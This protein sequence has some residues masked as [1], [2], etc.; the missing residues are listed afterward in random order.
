MAEAA[1][2]STLRSRPRRTAA[3]LRWD[4]EADVVVLGFGGAGACAAIEAKG[5]GA[6]VL[7][8]DAASAPG[9]STG[10]SGGVIYAGGGTRIQ[11]ACGFEDSPEN[12]RKY[13]QLQDVGCPQDEDKINA[14]VDSSVA[15]IDWLEALGVPFNETYLKRKNS[16]SVDEEGLMYSGNESAWPHNEVAAPVPRGHAVR[17]PRDYGG[18]KLMEVLVAAAGKRGVRVIC[19]ARGRALIQDDDGSMTGLVVIIDGREV[20]VRARNGVVICTG[21]FIMNDTMLR[22]H[23]PKYHAIFNAHTGNPN[24][25]GSGILMGMAAGA[26]TINM[27]EGHLT[28]IFYPPEEMLYGIIVNGHGQR[29]VNEDS[30]N[31]RTGTYCC[32]QYVNPSSRIYA[33]GLLGDFKDFKDGILRENMDVAATGESVE[34]LEFELEMVPGTLGATIEIYNRY[35]GK[36]EDPLWHKAARWLKPLVPPLAALDLTPG[37][38][39]FY[40]YMSLGGMHTRT[41]GEVLDLEGNVIPGLYAAGRATSGI[42][43]N[44]AT[45]W[46]GLSVG[47]AT[48]FGRLAG[49]QAAVRDGTRT[50]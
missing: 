33:V 28:M 25:D 47:D 11:K 2:T 40:P 7:A 45:Y 36:G 48:F 15:H 19:D 49:K 27:H 46:S 13:L 31:G 42:I 30:Y 34:E 18:A 41:T 38:G 43:R 22:H 17:A 12:M 10:L 20:N 29:F 1:N 3:V 32:N 5:A 50:N 8:F 14:Y 23:S 39:V 6:E 9:G 37:R 4:M 24:D 44:S 21:G 16:H 26:G 35:A